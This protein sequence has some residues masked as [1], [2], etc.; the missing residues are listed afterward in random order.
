MTTYHAHVASTSRD[1]DGQYDNDY[2][3]VQY[4]DESEYDFEIRMLARLVSVWA[5]K[6]TLDVRTD[7]DGLPIMEWSQPT[8]EGYVF[9]AAAFCRNQCNSDARRYRD[10]TAEAAGY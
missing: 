5:D 6:G 7:S 2:V 1:C 9:I 3:D 8:E 10:H 4:D